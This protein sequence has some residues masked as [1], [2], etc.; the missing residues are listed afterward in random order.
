MT[1]FACCSCLKLFPGED[2]S[3]L[4]PLRDA[5]FLLNL[6]LHIFN[7]VAWFNLKSRMVFPVRVFTKNCMMLRNLYCFSRN[8][9][10]KL[11]LFKVRKRNGVEGKLR[12]SA[13]V[14]AACRGIFCSAILLFF[15][16]LSRL[17]N[18]V[19][20]GESHKNVS[21]VCVTAS[22]VFSPG[23]MRNFHG[24]ARDC[25]QPRIRGGG[26]GGRPLP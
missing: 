8:K 26:R 3:L 13:V 22:A 21:F 11:S 16:A 4:I 23:F 9:R 19:F 17:Y 7:T 18:T 2:E 25:F 12:N 6:P 14:M 10:H 24:T 1:L 15:V 20:I 5:F